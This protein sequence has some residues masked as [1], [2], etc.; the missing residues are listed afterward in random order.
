MKEQG[1]GP[2]A[3]PP[4]PKVDPDTMGRDTLNQ[5]APVVIDHRRNPWREAKRSFCP[6][7]SLESLAASHPP[8]LPLIPVFFPTSPR[9]ITAA[10]P[11]VGGG[12]WAVTTCV[13]SVQT[14]GVALPPR[15][16]GASLHSVNLPS[17]ID[18]QTAACEVLDATSALDA[19]GTL[20]K[21]RDINLAAWHHHLSSL[22]RG[23][24]AW[25]SRRRR[26]IHTRDRSSPTMIFSGG[27][28]CGSHGASATLNGFWPRW[29]T[30][31]GSR[32]PAYSRT[33]RV[34]HTEVLP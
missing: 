26:A 17:K 12:R 15:R 9:P 16:R 11:G 24:L 30:G 33:C 25:S 28:I 21:T 22:P 7:A 2:L 18:D 10:I 20:Y 29:Q 19:L 32:I 6:M 3:H 23:R 27:W 31:M 8:V 13:S 1:C 5:L 14:T 4:V 34:S